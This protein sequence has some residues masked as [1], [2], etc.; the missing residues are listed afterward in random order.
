MKNIII[1]DDDAGIRDVFKLILERAGYS[2]TM[3]SG[4]ETLLTNDFT[5]P[6]LFVI[7]KQL[8]GVDGLVVCESLKH[9]QLT[10]NIPVI[11]VSASSYVARLAKEVGAD[12][13]VE[14]PFKIQTF[15]KLI[16]KYLNNTFN[17]HEYNSEE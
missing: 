6:D 1:A 15:I 10:K 4:G 9:N 12:E 13:F 5:L 11:M 16:E 17:N 14:K 3:Y 7:D 2:V 8:S